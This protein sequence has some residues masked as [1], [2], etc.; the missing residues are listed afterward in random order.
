M[1]DWGSMCASIIVYCVLCIC[2]THGTWMISFFFVHIIHN[3]NHT[4][5]IDVMLPFIYTPYICII[6]ILL[7]CSR[8]FSYAYDL[9][10]ANIYL[11][12]REMATTTEAAATAAVVTAAE[13]ER[14]TI[15]RVLGLSLSI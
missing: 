12:E 3:T 2:N 6:I 10:Y 9:L 13:K 1:N 8:D 15:V 14:K 7:R 5:R 11:Y 4:T